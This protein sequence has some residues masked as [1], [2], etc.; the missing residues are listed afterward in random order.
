MTIFIILK[1]QLSLGDFLPISTAPYRRKYAHTK[2]RGREGTVTCGICGR[3]VPKY[4]TFTITKGFRINDP[5]ILQQV[6]RRYIHLMTN[7]VRLCPSCAR[8]Q[9]VSQPGK[10]IRKKHMNFGQRH[11]NY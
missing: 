8:F 7:R 5:I 9:G 6:D 11:G 4:K 2:S 10:S 1:H 3:E